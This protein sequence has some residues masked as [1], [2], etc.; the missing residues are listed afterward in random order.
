MRDLSHRFSRRRSEGSER[1]DVTVGVG[2]EVLEKGQGWFD[3]RSWSHHLSYYEPSRL[4][5]LC[6]SVV[7]P[8]NKT[9]RLRTRVFDDL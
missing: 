7:T 9:N 2:E 3:R 5:R 6:G 1:R 4:W 8:T